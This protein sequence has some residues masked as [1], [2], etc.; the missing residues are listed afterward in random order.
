VFRRFAI[1]VFLVL[2]GVSAGART[3]PH[4]GG[5]LHVEIEGDGLTSPD[6]TVLHLLLDGLTAVGSQGDLEPA[7]AESWKSSNNSHRWEFSLR[8]AVQFHDGTPLTA[9]RVVASLNLACNGD[10][11]WTTVHAVGQSV[12][13]VGDSPMPNLPWLLALNQF[14]ISLP[15]TGEA[16]LPR[17]IG[18]GPFLLV[19]QKPSQFTFAANESYWGGRPY[20]DQVEVLANRSIRD[21]WLD[22]SVGRAD[23]VEVPP[24][25]L[26]Q[27]QQERLSVLVSQPVELV[28][29]EVSDSGALA[30]PVLRASIAQAVDRSAL[31]NVIFEKQGEVT[32]SLLPQSVTGYSFLFPTDRDV[33]E[34]NELR[35]GLTPPQ[36]TMMAEG[37]GTMQLASQRIALNLH[38]AGFTVQT[39]KPRSV[40]RSNLLLRK[41]PLEDGDAFAALEIL[42]RS[43]GENVSVPAGDPN[44]LYRAE[45]NVLDL[46]T[47]I[48]LLDLPRACAVGSRAHSVTLRSD[49]LPDLTRV[50][51]EGT[52]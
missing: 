8:P 32:A 44:A 16:K 15:D 23:I 4:Y 21:Q 45:Q 52:Q 46:K 47:L 43:A 22:L 48:P 17:S 18:T 3:R 13:F 38:E 9:D 7:L 12:V 2:V 27:A 42:L 41:L 25:D 29:L 5:T 49:G 19:A 28:V 24:Q 34:A 36:V 51:L 1:S 26:R 50:S 20:A 31:F 6:A 37:D 35:G 40:P 30:N 33:K 10:C 14:L 11:P 39:L